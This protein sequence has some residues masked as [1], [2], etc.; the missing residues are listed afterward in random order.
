M[1]ICMEYEGS[2][3]NHIGMKGG[4]MKKRKMA[5]ISKF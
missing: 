3:T 4:K 2:M 5:D 1:H